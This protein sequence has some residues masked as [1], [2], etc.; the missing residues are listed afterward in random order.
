VPLVRIILDTDPGVDDAL[1]I[2]YLAAQDD[3][4]IVAVGSVHGNVTA[5]VGALNALRVLELVGL[6]VPVAVG[7]ARPLA[8]PLATAEFVHGEDGLGGHAGPEPTGAAVGYSAAEQLVRFARANPGE[9]TVLAIGPLTNLALAVLLEPELPR[10]LRSVVVM[11]GAVSVPGNIT[12]YADANFYHDPEA[13]DL[14]LAAGFPDLTLVALDATERAR[15]DAQWLDAVAALEGPRARFASAL[16]DH[17]SRFY[18]NMFGQRLCTL[19]DPLAAAIMLDSELATYRT[20]PVGVELTGT[21]TRGQ[22]V[23]DVRRIAS[24]EHITTGTGFGR[25][26]VR[27]ADDV[28]VS[29]FLSRMF[30]ALKE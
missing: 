15:A 24:D 26:P 30:I 4:E 22:S 8:Q 11:G 9:L 21:H 10:L 14:V 27:V 25:V 16:L 20:I 13:A 2:M 28:D 6:E 23:A 5:P 18:A 3:A 17:Y 1:A 12:P 19:H 7:A 29:T